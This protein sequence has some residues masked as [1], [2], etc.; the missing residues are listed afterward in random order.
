MET[1]SGKIPAEAKTPSETVDVTALE[2]AIPPRD[3]AAKLIKR[4]AAVSAGLGVIPVPALDVT[5]IG[6]AQLLMVRSIAKIYG[7][8][9]AKD[10]GRAILSTTVGSIA[11]VV[12]GGGLGS[13]LKAIPVVGTI[14]GALAVPSIASLTTLTLGNVLANHLDAGGALE[15]LDLAKLRALFIAEYQAAKTKLSRKKANVPADT[16]ALAA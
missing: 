5:A 9:L 1:K 8:D 16:E 12:I 7:L 11:P 2:V 3:Q 6:G 15:D 14:A 13:I 10:R 4:Y